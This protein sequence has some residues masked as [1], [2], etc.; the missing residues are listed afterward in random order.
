MELLRP[1][2][3]GFLEQHNCGVY[4]RVSLNDERALLTSSSTR[5]IIAVSKLVKSQ[6][7]NFYPVNQEHIAVVPNG[8]NL[9]VFER[10]RKQTNRTELR[11]KVGCSRDDFLLLFVGNE[12]GRKGLRVVLQSLRAL[13]DRRV[14][15]LVVGNG[16]RARY[17]RLA[18]D[19]GVVDNV[20]FVGSVP[21]PEDLYFAADA[22]VLPSIY[23]PFGIVVLEAMAAGVP[24]ITSRLCG[25]TEEMRHRQHVFHLADPTSIEELTEAIRVLMRDETLRKTLIDEGSE[26]VRDYS[27]DNVAHEMLSV[28]NEIRY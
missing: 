6:I 25:A 12:F 1:Y 22:F 4:D 8:V 11:S 28:Y 5:K 15:L 24:V 23:E 2:S 19:L 3:S 14:R 10:L 9:A 27:W 16:D 18:L 20:H 7:E 17:S 26:K 13:D 21:G